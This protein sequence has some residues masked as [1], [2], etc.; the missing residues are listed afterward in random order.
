MIGIS[1]FDLTSEIPI[2]TEPIDGNQLFTENVTVNDV[3]ETLETS[4]F[5]NELTTS[6][7]RN[8]RIVTDEIIDYRV[9]V[10]GR[11]VDQVIKQGLY[12]IFYHPVHRRFVALCPKEPA[13]RISDIFVNRFGLQLRKHQFNIPEII[14]QSTDVRGAGFNVQIE[15]I[16]GLTMRGSAVNSTAYYANMV[17]SGELTGV[18]VQMD[19]AGKTVTFR[20][21]ADG[22]LLVYSAM[23]DHEYLDF[24]D[25]LYTI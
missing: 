6:G 2:G 11:I 24:V 17:T 15:T 12:E 25:M 1:V 4:V 18:T 10:L 3:E 14:N 8:Y 19:F 20:V 13:F 7:Y 23:T 22:G 16:R 21:S 5:V 9:R